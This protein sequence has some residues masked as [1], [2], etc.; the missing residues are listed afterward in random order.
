MTWF[1]RSPDWYR[2]K[3]RFVCT[4]DLSCIRSSGPKT[5]V[6]D[7]FNNGGFWK[8]MI[9]RFEFLENLFLPCAA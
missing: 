2:A 4:A 7:T 1:F 8:D 9:I 3:V 5:T 6:F